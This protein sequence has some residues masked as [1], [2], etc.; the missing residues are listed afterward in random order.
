M[1]TY[2][3][4]SVVCIRRQPYDAHDA[5]AH[6]HTHDPASLLD[7]C[8]W[9]RLHTSLEAVWMEQLLVRWQHRLSHISLAWQGTWKL[10]TVSWLWLVWPG[11]MVTYLWLPCVLCGHMVKTEAHLAAED[12]QQQ[13][14]KFWV[15]TPVA[16]SPYTSLTIIKLTL[17]F[18]PFF[19]L[20]LSLSYALSHSLLPTH[21]PITQTWGETV[22]DSV[23]RC[24]TMSSVLT[25]NA[26]QKSIWRGVIIL[27]SLTRV[28]Q[29]NSLTVWEIALV[30]F[31][32]S[33]TRGLMHSYVCSKKRLAKGKQRA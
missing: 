10:L 7:G 25:L 33:H 1:D 4:H 2:S 8:D 27:S 18:L 22:G 19:I 15:F 26:N 16:A 5:R 23:C 20:S 14:V 30:A 24:S 17:T 31:M 13:Q 6:T 3:T 21:S 9:E 32:Q 11:V 29:R 12:W 28:L